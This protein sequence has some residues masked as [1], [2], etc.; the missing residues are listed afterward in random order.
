[1]KIRFSPIAWRQFDYQHVLSTF[2]LGTHPEVTWQPFVGDADVVRARSRA[3]TSFL[4]DTEDDLL[5]MIDSDIVF[6]DDEIIRMCRRTMEHDIVGGLYW[7][8]TPE[9][10]RPPCSL[11]KRVRVELGSDELHP[12]RYTAGGCFAAHRRVFE[13]LAKDLPLCN[14]D[15]LRYYPFF[16]KMIVED[17]DNGTIDLSED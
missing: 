17:P 8:R 7:T 15:D 11:E 5:L 4:L 16:A 14:K 13:R 2:N 10:A 6:N 9:G 1:M 3:A 12:L